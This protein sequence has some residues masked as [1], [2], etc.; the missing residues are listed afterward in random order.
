MAPG[1]SD[2]YQ[3]AGAVILELEKIRERN[4]RPAATRAAV[5]ARERIDAAGYSTS[6]TQARRTPPEI[7]RIHANVST[8]QVCY[9]CHKPLP[10]RS[11]KCPACGEKQ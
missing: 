4:R 2:R 8:R 11:V 3:I 1:V 9:S 5:D 10:P 6:L 7:P